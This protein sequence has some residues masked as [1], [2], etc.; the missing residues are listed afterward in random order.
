MSEVADF[1]FLLAISC[2]Q[3]GLP[4]MDACLSRAELLQPKEGSVK[5]CVEMFLLSPEPERGLVIGLAYVKGM[6]HPALVH[7]RIC[8]IMAW[9]VSMLHHALP[10]VKCTFSYGLSCAGPCLGAG[11]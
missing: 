3:A 7:V 2:L 9:N 4:S 11:R 5:E 6:L 1:S 10:H 8:P